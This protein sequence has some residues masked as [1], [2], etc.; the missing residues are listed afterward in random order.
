MIIDVQTSRLADG[1]VH[2]TC[3]F[4]TQCN[5]EL[6]P[7]VLARWAEL[8]ITVGFSCWSRLEHPR[9]TTHPVADARAGRFAPAEHVKRSLS[10]FA[11]GP[12][13][14]PTE[15]EQRLG[16]PFIDKCEVGD[17]GRYGRHL[18]QPV[19]EGRGQLS[20][21]LGREPPHRLVDHWLI[22]TPDALHTLA[23]CG[24]TDTWLC[25][26]LSFPDDRW[27]FELGA[28][29]LVALARLEMTVGVSCY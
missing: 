1:R 7:E 11:A 23:A 17:I 27:D 5:L 14:S 25:L 29:E 2:L 19:A 16:H 20:V 10:F 26:N 8:S 24:A 6:G 15:A 22:R 9:R 4:D 3:E 28:D 13:L 18:G 21:E 12:E